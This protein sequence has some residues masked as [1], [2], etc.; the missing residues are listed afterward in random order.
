MHHKGAIG[1]VF[2][3]MFG[4]STSS[5]WDRVIFHLA[6]LVVVL[7]LVIKVYSLKFGDFV[8]RVFWFWRSKRRKYL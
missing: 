3:A 2:A 8:G 7:P 4:Y 6:Y 1:P 5:E